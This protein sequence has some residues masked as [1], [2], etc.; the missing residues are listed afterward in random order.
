MLFTPI[1]FIINRI[2]IWYVNPCHLHHVID[3]LMWLGAIY[4]NN[5]ADV[6]METGLPVNNLV[7]FQTFIQKENVIIR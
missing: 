7:V 5:I 2:A 1:D 6:G 3:S 4:E